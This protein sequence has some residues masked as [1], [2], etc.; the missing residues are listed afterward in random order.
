MQIA[1]KECYETEYWLSIF[2]DANLLEGKSAL[3]DCL[4]LRRML[5][6]SIKTAKDVK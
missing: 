3:E 2:I 6:A 5:I 4:E 1:L